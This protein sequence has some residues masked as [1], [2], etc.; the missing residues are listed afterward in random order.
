ME[1]RR[2]DF[3]V[4]ITSF[5]T[6]SAVQINAFKLTL[7]FLFQPHPL[8]VISMQPHPVQQQEEQQKQQPEE[9]GNLTAQMFK[10]YTAVRLHN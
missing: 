2:K 10:N 9:K 6:D 7:N 5:F 1:P 8:P 3:F 4:T